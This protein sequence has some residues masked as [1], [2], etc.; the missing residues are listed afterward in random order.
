[1]INHSGQLATAVS[2]RGTYD[3]D[4]Y[5]IRQTDEDASKLIS[6]REIMKM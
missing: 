3:R 1:M 2:H 4:E 6:F 5:Q